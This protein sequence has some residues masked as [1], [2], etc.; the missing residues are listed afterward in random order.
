MTI[1]SM[2]KIRQLITDLK[3]DETLNFYM[4]G[5]ELIIRERPELLC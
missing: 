2:N 1:C 5:R 4:V 3:K